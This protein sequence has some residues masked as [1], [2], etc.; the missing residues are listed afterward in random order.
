MNEIPTPPPA[1]SSAEPNDDDLRTLLAKRQHAKPTKATWI[2]L[3]L[4]AVA[5]GFTF[6]ACVSRAVPDTIPG[7][8]GAISEPRSVPT[9]RTA[10]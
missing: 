5:I 2:L 7:P 3:A 6:G 4:I 9:E 1:S 8:P 10:P